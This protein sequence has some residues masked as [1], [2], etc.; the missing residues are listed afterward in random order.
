MAVL[1]HGHSRD[2][3]RLVETARTSCS[4]VLC[5]LGQVGHEGGG[6][7][8]HSHLSRLLIAHGMCPGGTH[9]DFLS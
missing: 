8:R 1:T 2:T 6:G 7:W 4:A 9:T 3:G 5:A